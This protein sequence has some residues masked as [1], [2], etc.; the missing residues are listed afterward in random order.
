MICREDNN[1]AQ[2]SFQ[3]TEVTELLPYRGNKV[4]ELKGGI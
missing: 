2:V 3:A 4:A 1:S